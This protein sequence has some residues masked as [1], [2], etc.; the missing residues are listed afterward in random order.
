M[1]S[2]RVSKRCNGSDARSGIEAKKTNKVMG[3][4]HMRTEQEGK[5]GNPRSSHAK[6]KFYRKSSQVLKPRDNKYANVLREI[7]QPKK[8]KIAT[9]QFPIPFMTLVTVRSPAPKVVC[10]LRPLP[11]GCGLWYEPGIWLYGTF[12][13]IRP[14]PPS[15]RIGCRTHPNPAIN[16]SRYHSPTGR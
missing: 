2:A 15:H 6:G 10:M 9:P 12:P 5:G 8:S 7:P 1:V 14:C 11:F 3:Y 4:R 16:L 13:F